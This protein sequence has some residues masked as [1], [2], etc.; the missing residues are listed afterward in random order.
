MSCVPF[1]P[2]QEY[3]YT[4]RADGKRTGA[5]ET[6]W[7]DSNG[8]GTREPHTNHLTWA[9][10]DVGR[11][12]DEVLDHFDNSL[13]QTEHFAYDPAGNRLSMTVDQGN[14]G[15]VDEAIAYLYDANDRLKTELLDIGDNSSVDQ[16]TTYG[17]NRTQQSS[18]I[19][20]DATN[21]PLSALN[22]F[23]GLQG[24]MSQ[25]DTATYSGGLVSHRGTEKGTQGTE[26][27][28]QREQKRG[29][30]SFLLN[31]AAVWAR[32]LP[33]RAVLALPLGDW[34]ITHSTAQWLVCRCFRRTQT[35]PPLCG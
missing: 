31:W 10:D 27:G 7:L 16:T 1:S 12:V 21:A 4:V 35:T 17:Y 29:R 6:F 2:S 32:L 18:K 14:N 15:S 30:S 24:R 34:S 3:D 33:C 19:V 23:Y 25:V 9:Y 22:F 11:L 5:T 8:D 28:T 26:K 13:D 20:T